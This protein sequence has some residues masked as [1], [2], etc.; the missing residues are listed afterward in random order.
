MWLFSHDFPELDYHY[1]PPSPIAGANHQVL[2]SSE[3]RITIVGNYV[4]H[5]GQTWQREV[6]G[7][8]V[9]FDGTNQYHKFEL[10]PNRGIMRS[11]FNE[12]F[13]HVDFTLQF[14]DYR[15]YWGLSGAY[16]DY[17]GYEPP[18]EQEVFS[19][20]ATWY[21]LGYEQPVK[22]QAYKLLGNIRERVYD[23]TNP[24]PELVLNENSW[25]VD[26]STRVEGKFITLAKVREA[27][28]MLRE[29]WRNENW[30]GIREGASAAGVDAPSLA[31]L[32]RLDNHMLDIITADTA[33][34]NEPDWQSVT[35]TGLAENVIRRYGS[36]LFYFLATAEGH[37][38]HCGLCGSTSFRQ[39]WWYYQ[40]NT[41]SEN[42]TYFWSDTKY[43]TDPYSLTLDVVYTYQNLTRYVCNSCGAVYGGKSFD[44][45][46]HVPFDNKSR[47]D[48]YANL[49]GDGLAAETE[50]A[51]FKQFKVRVYAPVYTGG[52]ARVRVLDNT[53]RALL[54]ARRD[55]LLDSISGFIFES[56]SAKWTS[57]ETAD[58]TGGGE[59]GV[60]E[61]V[62]RRP[63]TSTTVTV[64]ITNAWGATV[65]QGPFY[66]EGYQSQL[67]SD[68]VYALLLGF[69]VTVVALAVDWVMIRLRGRR[70]MHQAGADED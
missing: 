43:A 37:P 34:E 57:Y 1:T 38:A 67:G 27:L 39:Q 56:S 70:A 4:N 53:G 33:A 24:E 49:S 32:S 48:F 44:D 47:L 65:V 7:G 63:D 64:E 8:A 55:P 22:F 59:N 23:N 31:V 58:I 9:S 52:L 20:T 61:Y 19:T 17:T 3:S 16:E 62:L 29:N 28:N 11:M 12:N 15:Q 69:F 60:Y 6:R 66:V 26:W 42:T 54:F 5:F 68:I 36:E 14:L 41:T 30:A 46:I 2:T 40:E 45:L 51:G 25:E 21:P 18:F 13:T 50:N 35:G 10:R